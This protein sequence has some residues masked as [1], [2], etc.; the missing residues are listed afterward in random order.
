MFY[1]KHAQHS[2]L[3]TENTQWK[4]GID[5]YTVVVITVTII[6]ASFQGQ[7]P[8]EKGK[9]QGQ[10]VNAQIGSNRVCVYKFESLS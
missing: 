6:T 4:V 7:A 1:T 10:C 5:G 2:I 9:T 8:E 3:H